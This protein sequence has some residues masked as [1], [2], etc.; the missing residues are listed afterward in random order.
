MEKSRL[1]NLFLSLT[2]KEYKAFR[3]YLLSPYHN[4]QGNLVTLFDYMQES[5]GALKLV[6]TKEAAFV[7]LF[8]KAVYKDSKI[9]LAMSSLFKLMEDFLVD[10]ALQKDEVNA[11]VKLA[12]IYRKRN[13]PKHFNRTLAE[14]KKINEEKQERNVEFYDDRLQIYLEE[15]QFLS[16][17]QRSLDFNLQTISD[18][19]D[20]AFMARKLRQICVLVSHQNVYNK[21]YDFGLLPQII[22]YIEKGNFLDI[23]AVGVYYYVYKFLVTEEVHYFNAFKVLIFE[24]GDVFPTEEIRDL[25]LLGVNYCIKM[26]NAGQEHFAKEGIDL[27]KKGLE[28]AYFFTNGILSRFTYR[29][30][31]AAGLIVKDYDF[32]EQFIYKYKDKLEKKYR[33]SS[34]NFDLAQLEYE[35]KNYDKALECL[36]HFEYKDL[37]INLVAKTTQMKIYYEKDDFDVLDSH[38]DSMRIFIRRK[39]ILGYHKEHYLK[40]IYYTKKLLDLNPFDKKSKLKLMEKIEGEGRLIVKDW[41]LEKLRGL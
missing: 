22:T 5:T 27:Y 14:L 15:Y 34:F 28:K 18:T 41:L 13:L 30:I 20:V 4:T 40:V 31:T 10:N 19:I 25:Y 21:Q 36:Q 12:E 33:E 11:K 6:P 16:L 23:P 39:N 8:P 32:V 7:K 38:L 24:K 17:N 29:N 37:L 26:I 3:Q 2:N 1:Y 35:K 9:R